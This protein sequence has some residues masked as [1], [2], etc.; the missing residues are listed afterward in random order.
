MA[1]T[2]S[3]IDRCDSNSGPIPEMLW[4]RQGLSPEQLTTMEATTWPVALPSGLT[5][6][7]ILRAIF[8]SLAGNQ[9]PAIRAHVLVKK[10]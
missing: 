10:G 8:C 2:E 3:N 1:T 6:A 5:K 4:C 9:V 7:A